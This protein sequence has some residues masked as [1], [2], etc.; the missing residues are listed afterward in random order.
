MGDRHEK[1]SEVLLW[2]IFLYGGEELWRW[3]FVHG[4]GD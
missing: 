4:A 2:Q 1:G 3:P